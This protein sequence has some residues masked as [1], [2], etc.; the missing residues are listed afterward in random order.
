MIMKRK[1]SLV[2][3]VLMLSESAWSQFDY[4]VSKDTVRKPVAVISRHFSGQK[5]LSV[6]PNI[7]VNNDFGTKIAGGVKFQ[8][9]LGSRVSLDADL[10]VGKDYIHT[11]PGIIALPFWLLF[12]NGSDVELADNGG[13]S[14]F[15]FMLAAGVLSFEH[16]SYHIPLR[17]DWEIT[18]YVSLLRFR[19]AISASPESAVEGQ[20]SFATGVQADKYIGRFFISPYAEYNIGYKDRISQFNAGIGFGI[21]FPLRNY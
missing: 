6:S 13:F 12:F 2:I 18:P 15:L 21:L 20:F 3:I 1:I 19:Q 17:K 8:V 9:F 11:G 7:L 5:T 10:V 14:D 16:I 4:Y